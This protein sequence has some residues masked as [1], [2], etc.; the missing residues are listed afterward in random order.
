MLWAMSIWLDTGSYTKW[1]LE[2]PSKSPD[3]GPG[4]QPPGNDIIYIYKMALKDPRETRGRGPGDR[5]PPLGKYCIKYYIYKMAL[6]RALRDPSPGDPWEC[7]LNFDTPPPLREGRKLRVA[8]T[9]SM[10]MWHA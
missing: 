8:S 9:R 4:E 5:E 3:R 2:D 10:D 1:P 6:N 7:G